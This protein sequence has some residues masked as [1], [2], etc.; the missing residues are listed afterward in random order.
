[1][2]LI[3]TALLAVILVSAGPPSGEKGRPSVLPAKLTVRCLNKDK[4]LPP[5]GSTLEV[6]LAFECPRDE[7]GVVRRG[8]YRL[9][10]LDKNGRQLDKRIFEVGDPDHTISL[11]KGVVKD[12]FTILFP[13]SDDIVGGEDYSLVFVLRDKA[14]MVKFQGRKE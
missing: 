8:E 2:R 5:D 12:T 14:G 9:M 10:V 11:R 3:L 1:M 4:V 13:A 6:E 7:G